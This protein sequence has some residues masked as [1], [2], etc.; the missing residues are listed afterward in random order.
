MPVRAALVDA[1]CA[2]GQVD[3]DWQDAFRAVP[4]ELFV[5]DAVWTGGTN[6]TNQDLTSSASRAATGGSGCGSMSPTTWSA[7]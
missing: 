1:L 6:K 3:G 5:P 4:R 2:A 7:S